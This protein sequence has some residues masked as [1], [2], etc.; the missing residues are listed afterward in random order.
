MR[1]TVKYIVLL[2]IVL[3]AASCGDPKPSPGPDNHSKVNFAK[4]ADV[5]WVT[6]MERDGIKFYNSRVQRWSVWPYSKVWV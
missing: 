5:S 1:R 3:T 6:Q 4:G 2:L